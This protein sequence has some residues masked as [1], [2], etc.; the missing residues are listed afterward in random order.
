LLAQKER[1]VVQTERVAAWRETGAAV[2]HTNCAKHPL[3]FPMQDHGRKIC[4]K[5][6]P[7]SLDAKQFLEVFP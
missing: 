4:R 5:K 3:L 6:A 7:A 1:P 2:S